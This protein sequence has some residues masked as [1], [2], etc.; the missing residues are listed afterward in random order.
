MVPTAECGTCTHLH[1]TKNQLK[2]TLVP[3]R[4]NNSQ[5]KAFALQI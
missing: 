4:Q 3:K 2:V 5:M 1:I